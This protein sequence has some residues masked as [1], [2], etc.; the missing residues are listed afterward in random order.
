MGGFMR[1]R[2]LAVTGALALICK[3]GRRAGS[4]A[5]SDMVDGMAGTVRILPNSA[6]AQFGGFVYHRGFHLQCAR[7][8]RL[9][10]DCLCPAG[11]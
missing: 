8:R 10:P 1:K 5:Q 4:A 11:K 7:K 3:S 2:I 9:K 6:A